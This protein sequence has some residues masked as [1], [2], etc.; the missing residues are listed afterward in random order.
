MKKTAL[1]PVKTWQFYHAAKHHLGI[2]FLQ[3]LFKVSPRQIDRWACDPDFAESSQRNPMDRYETLLKKLMELGA[4]D[5]ARATV[6][7]Q[8]AI[9][10]CSLVCDG[11]IIPDKDTLTEELLD[12]LPAIAK[13]HTA[14]SEGQPMGVVRDLAAKAINDIRE[15]LAAYE[16]Q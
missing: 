14:I 2:A 5:V 1:I 9:I 13:L 3:K 15:D 7:R 11:E 12:D 6:D 4:T 16:R 8:A 10:G